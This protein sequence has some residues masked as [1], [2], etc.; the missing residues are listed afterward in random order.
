MMLVF[1]SLECWISEGSDG[2]FALLLAKALEFGR[3]NC[4]FLYIL[5]RHML[6]I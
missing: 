4:V 1:W 6:T 5:E 3:V 2:G